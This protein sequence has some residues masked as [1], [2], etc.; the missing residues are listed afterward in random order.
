M[1]KTI[2]LIALTIT[3]YATVH[4]QDAYTQQMQQFANKTEEQITKAQSLLDTTKQKNELSE[5]YCVQMMLNQARVFINP[6]TYGPRYGPAANNYMHL[7]EKSNP[8]NPRMLY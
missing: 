1:K 6:Q 4:A 8:D 5:V 2:F 7:A 3:M